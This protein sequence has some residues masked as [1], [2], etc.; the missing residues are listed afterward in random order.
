MSPQAKQWV[1]AYFTLITSGRWPQNLQLS[2][3][4][5]RHSDNR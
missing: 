2:A 5:Y 3:A 1:D 4:L